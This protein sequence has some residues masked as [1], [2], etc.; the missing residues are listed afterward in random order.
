[1]ETR[2]RKNR[3]EASAPAWLEPLIK[4]VCKCKHSYLEVLN[5]FTWLGENRHKRR[6]TR[7]DWPQPSCHVESVQ[8]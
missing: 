8:R 2:L 5:D 3:E 1:M 6:T 7:E 4:K